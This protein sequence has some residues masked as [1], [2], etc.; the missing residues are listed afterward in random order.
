ML[1]C[2]SDIAIDIVVEREA[3]FP[4]LKVLDSLCVMPFENLMAALGDCN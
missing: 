1:F 4:L 2:T 3:K